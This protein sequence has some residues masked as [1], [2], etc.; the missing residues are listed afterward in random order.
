V[1]LLACGFG[2]FRLG[3]VVR[4]SPNQGGTIWD[5][6]CPGYIFEGISD[7]RIASVLTGV[8]GEF[9]FDDLLPGA[10]TVIAAGYP[11]V[12]VQVQLGAGLTT[13]TVI[14]LQSPSMAHPVAGNG[15]AEG[16]M[17]AGEGRQAL[18][19]SRWRS[20][21]SVRAPVL[22]TTSTPEST[23]ACTRLPQWG[24]LRDTGGPRH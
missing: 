1:S 17:L 14:T 20:T 16:R 3:N 24:L 10:Y 8:D 4:S 23:A 6:T 11:A 7:T 12:A 18:N 22:W 21:L 2:W 9:V 15:V 5:F 19:R 13:E